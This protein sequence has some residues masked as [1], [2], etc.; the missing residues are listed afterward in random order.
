MSN[1]LEQAS[2]LKQ[3]HVAAQEREDC[4]RK[5]CSILNTGLSAPMLSELRRDCLAGCV[6]LH[7][8][9]SCMMGKQ[10]RLL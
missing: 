7:K 3:Q 10:N 2:D 4:I 8:M 5:P 6:V 1:R 9:M